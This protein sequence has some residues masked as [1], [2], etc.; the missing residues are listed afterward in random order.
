MIVK[1]RRKD[2]RHAEARLMAFLYTIPASSTGPTNPNWP[3]TAL[4]FVMFM[5]GNI[6]NSCSD[7]VQ[8]AY[9]GFTIIS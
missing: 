7:I 4:L 2:A 3:E 1:P 6:W 5:G 8:D 9:R